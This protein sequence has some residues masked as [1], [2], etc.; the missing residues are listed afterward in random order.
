[1]NQTHNL[2]NANLFTRLG[3][4]G[5]NEQQQATITAQVAELIQS[6]VSN[7]VASFLGETDIAELTKLME[8]NNPDKVEAFVRDRIPGYDELVREI[9]E[10]TIDELAAQKAEVMQAIKN[11]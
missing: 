8:E 4:E 2:Q 11:S 10:E 6:R 1:M 5:L 7:R 9:S 3:M